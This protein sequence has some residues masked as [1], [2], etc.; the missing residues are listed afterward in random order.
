[1]PL[2][3][4][5]GPLSVPLAK[6]AELIAACPAW[7]TECQR[8]SL[9]E[10]LPAAADEVKAARFIDEDELSGELNCPL[11]RVILVDLDV[12]NHELNRIRLGAGSLLLE[13]WLPAR[14]DT[15]QERRR[16][17]RNTV[18]TLF[19][20]MF[21]RAKA[22]KPD[23]TGFYWHLTQLRRLITPQEM[24]D[25]QARIGAGDALYCAYQADWIE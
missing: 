6:A 17:F 4:P 2:P 22:P 12:L 10:Q 13:C 21:A 20:E 9:W 3:A 24:V 11:P 19:Q 25:T 15:I 18:G 7:Q 23:G 8:S 1:M 5:I 16:H 14:G